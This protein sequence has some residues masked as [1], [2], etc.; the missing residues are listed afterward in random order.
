MGFQMTMEPFWGLLLE[1]VVI[2]RLVMSRGQIMENQM[3]LPQKEKEDVL[4]RNNHVTG[5][6]IFNC[7]ICK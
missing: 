2:T 5:G 6:P 1:D 7:T 4:Q 3:N